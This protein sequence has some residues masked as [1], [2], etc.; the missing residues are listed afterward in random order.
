M[1]FP[2]SHNKR[3]GD[4]GENFAVNLLKKNGYKIINRNFRSKF[5]EIDIIAIKNKALI[6]IEVKCRWSKKFGAPE[7]AVTYAKIKKL[8]KSAEYFSLLHPDL[9]NKLL[10]EVVALEVT[11][12]QIS[13]AKII[14]VD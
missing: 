4:L 1:R 5:G 3:I 10:I 7:E 12:N 13:S 14:E 8:R 2:S 6:F 11:E 9:P